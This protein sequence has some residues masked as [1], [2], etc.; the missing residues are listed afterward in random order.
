MGVGSVQDDTVGDMLIPEAA[1]G[2]VT[3]MAAS[4]SSR[5]LRQQQQVAAQNTFLTVLAALLG[6]V[7]LVALGCCLWCLVRSRKLRRQEGVGVQAGHA[8]GW[9][10]YADQQGVA[11]P[12]GE[13]PVDNVPG[14]GGALGRGGDADLGQQ[15]HRRPHSA[16]QQEAGIAMAALGGSSA[17]YEREN[18]IL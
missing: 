4:C 12:W 10:G 13:V 17:A 15:W 3:A 18:G 9:R 8:D 5:E 6:V 11:G 7:L 16:R 14:N 2:R 1:P